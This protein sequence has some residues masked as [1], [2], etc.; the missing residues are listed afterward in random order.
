LPGSPLPGAPLLGAP[1][2]GA[3]TWLGLAGLFEIVWVV[4]LK[5]SEGLTRLGWSA[6]TVAAIGSSFFCMAQAL[7]VLPM[8]TV[9]AVWT[10]I[11]A[12]GGLFWGI[13]AEGE[14]ATALRIGCV[15]LILAGVAG[16]KLGN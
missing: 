6:A 7:R 10:G 14:P 13:V 11:G 2:F 4:L 12:A 9:Y 3:W 15:C 8:G 5:Q 16:L 1:F